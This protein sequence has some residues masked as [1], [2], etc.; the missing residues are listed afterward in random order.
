M[1]A[2]RSV[3]F[4]RGHSWTENRYFG[5]DFSSAELCAQGSRLTVFLQ[6]SAVSANLNDICLGLL[7]R[8]G[9]SGLINALSAALTGLPL[10]SIPYAL[11]F[12]CSTSPGDQSS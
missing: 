7:N 8:C 5:R 9:S 6:T 4:L 10:I 2:A 3:K 11:I 1:L 12:V